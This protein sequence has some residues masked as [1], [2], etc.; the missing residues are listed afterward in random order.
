MWFSE[1]NEKLYFGTCPKKEIPE[2]DSL[3]EEEKYKVNIWHY[4]DPKIQPQQLK[5]LKEE[6]KRTY[7]AVYHLESEKVFQIEDTIITD[8]K[9]PNKGN[10]NMALGFDVLKYYKENTWNFPPSRDAYIINLVTGEKKLFL[11]N[12]KDAIN[13][14]PGG[15]YVLWFNA[16]EDTW[17]SKNTQTLDTVNLTEKLNVHFY[18]EDDDTPSDPN[19]YGLAGWLPEDSCIWIYDRYDIW[20]FYPDNNEKPI[21]I[22]KGLGR[23]DSTIFRYIK[24]DRD[25]PYIDTKDVLLSG[26]NKQNKDDGFARLANDSVVWLVKGPFMFSRPKKAKKAEKYIYTKQ[27]YNT[28]PDL[29]F[30]DSTFAQSIQISNANPQM[31]KYLWG[32]VEKTEWE[33]ANGKKISGLI[34]KPENFN[35]DKKYP[36]IVYFYEKYSDRIHRH[37]TPRPSASVINFPLYVSNDYIVFIPDIYYT[38]GQP[39]QDAY[40]CIISGTNHMLEKGYV[41]KNK[42]GIQG[43]SWGGYQVA[44]LVTRT[45]I[46]AAAEAGAPVSNMTSAYGGIRWGSGLSRMFQYEKGQSRLGVTLWENPDLYLKNSPVFYADKITTPLLI[47]H[48]DHDGAVPWYQGIELYMALRRLDKKVWMLS[49][50]NEEHNLMKRPNRVDLS[51]RMMQFFDHYLKDQSTPEWMESGRPAIEKENNDAYKLINN[52]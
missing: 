37:Y 41:N 38:T 44:Y 27:N 22:T 25:N 19:P 33:N 42:I 24:T 10:S 9:I 17:Y 20:Q 12:L 30:T 39:G 51:I 7:T 34:Y 5:E 23:K 52:E 26:F 14:S 47:M 18:N 31:E 49:Y 21:N 28:Y 6:K 35:P 3:L 50:E 43:Q 36:M 45:D 11:E 46:Y 29:L 2:E 48:N 32:S 4:D 13:I 40:D 1:N 16:K 8:T 15:R